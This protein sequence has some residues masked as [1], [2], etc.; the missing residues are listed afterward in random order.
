MT[1][2]HGD[3][4]RSPSSVCPANRGR[5]QG[6]VNAKSVKAKKIRHRRSEVSGFSVEVTEEKNKKKNES[7][8]CVTFKMSLTVA[9]A[10][11]CQV[12]YRTK[13]RSCLP[14]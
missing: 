8:K 14:F 7:L 9:G 3:G 1:L 12:R 4:Q 13:R 5:K 6:N 10:L 11:D 2:G